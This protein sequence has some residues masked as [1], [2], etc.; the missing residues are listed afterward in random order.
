[1]LPDDAAAFAAERTIRP[2]GTVQLLIRGTVDAVSSCDLMDVLIQGI[3]SGRTLIV[4]L[5][6]AT[7]IDDTAV[8]ALAAADDIASQHGRELRVLG[9]TREVEALLRTIRSGLEDTAGHAR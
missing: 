5:A 2:D 8:A 7:L 4:D 1:M 9:C 6:P 3:A